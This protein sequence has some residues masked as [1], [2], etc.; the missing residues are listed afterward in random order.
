MSHSDDP[1]AFLTGAALDTPRPLAVG[2]KFKADGA[3]LPC[4]GNTT[5]CHV[6]PASP[7]HASLTRAQMALQAGQ[8][9]NA[10]TFLPPASFHMTVFEGVIETARRPEAWPQHLPTDVP[11]ADVT[12][13]LLPRLQ[14]A[15]LPERLV[16]RPTQIFG[17]F[18]L[19][20]TGATEADEETLREA[21]DEIATATGIH[22]PYHDGYRFHITMAY[23]LRWLTPDEAAAVIAL[24][25]ETFV[26]LLS[27]MPTLTLGPIEFCTFETMHHFEPIAHLGSA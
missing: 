18:G 3:V 21:R 15:A 23:L 5:L 12:A 1:L 10:F 6:D 19:T 25:A 13:D 27:E 14:S 26:T 22:R 20:L 8:H 4:P 9:A 16:V 24:S 2:Q 17:G 7:A 11:I